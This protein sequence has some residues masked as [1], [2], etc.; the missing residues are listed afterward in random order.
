MTETRDVVVIGAGIVGCSVAYAL[1]GEGAKPLVL[2]RGEIGREASWAGGGILNPIRPH[3][4]PEALL[5]ICE[6]GVEAYE[7]WIP[8]IAEASGIDPEYDE[9]GELLLLRDDDDE[10]DAAAIAAF[11][12][13]AGQPVE[14]LTAEQLAARVPGLADGFRRALLFPDIRQVRN[15]RLNR[16][17]STAAERAGVEFRTRTPVEGLLR[18]GERV[19]GVRTAAGEVHAGTTVLAAG[20]WSGADALGLGDRLPVTPVRG[21]I[22]LTDLQPV[23]F[24]AMLL[25]KDHY[26]IPRRDGK[27]LLGSTLEEAG[28]DCKTT[29]RGVH[30]I[31]QRSQAILP[32]LAESPFLTAWAGLRPGTPDRLPYIGAVPGAE[33]L[34]AATGHYRNGLLLGPITGEIIA[35]LHGGREPPLD[36]TPYLP[37]RVAPAA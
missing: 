35:A 6:R 22:V 18:D 25:W 2:E 3:V 32:G 23:T 7:R 9:V 31:L 29:A 4:Y 16:A 12:R 36:V 21:Q 8:R 19:I 34:L 11:K 33:G 15:P 10:A 24:R 13:K 37:D 30:G 26:I 1:A 17:L 20:A 5:P 28:F 14:E 27:V